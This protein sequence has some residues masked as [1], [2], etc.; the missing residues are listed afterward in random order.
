MAPYVMPDT[1]FLREKDRS[2]LRYKSP[3]GKFLNESHSLGDSPTPHMEP[4][5]SRRSKHHLQERV[6]NTNRNVT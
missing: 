2:V 4:K 6:V 3:L 1:L 5:K